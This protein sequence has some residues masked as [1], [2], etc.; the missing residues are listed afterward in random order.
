MS[1]LEYKKPTCKLLSCNEL[2]PSYQNCHMCYKSYCQKNVFD[3]T[4]NVVEQDDNSYR[5]EVTV[6]NKTDTII[7][8]L[9]LKEVLVMKCF[10]YALMC[11]QI[12][13]DNCHI[14]VASVTDIPYNVLETGELLLPDSY[15]CPYDEFR[16]VYELFY[17]GKPTKMLKVN[18]CTDLSGTCTEHVY[19]K[20]CLEPVCYNTGDLDLSLEFDDSLTVNSST[21]Y[22]FNESEC[23]YQIE[24]G[25]Y[26]GEFVMNNFKR[27]C[28]TPF[29][30]YSFNYTVRNGYQ[31]VSAEAVTGD[32]C[33][34]SILNLA[35]NT[36]DSTISGCF[37]APIGRY[38][39]FSDNVSFTI[40]Q[41]RFRFKKLV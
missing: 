13:Q 9:S 8:N 39:N 24:G 25:L 4:H 31:L 30:M 26:G 34:I 35:R 17:I 22:M 7:K 28:K 33:V 38:I 15:L 1:K 41:L 5:I 36:V 23:V 3:I 20:V 16:I 18:S 27:Y 2:C 19:S 6:K 29:K 21:P 14:H 40:Q 32:N 12:I 37:T 11:V 10:K